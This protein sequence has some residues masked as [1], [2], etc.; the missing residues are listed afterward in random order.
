M[1]LS[2][3]AKDFINKAIIRENEG[4]EPLVNLVASLDPDI[5]HNSLNCLISLV[6]VINVFKERQFSQGEIKLK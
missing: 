6:E 2:H 1:F 3:M 4:I 5:Q